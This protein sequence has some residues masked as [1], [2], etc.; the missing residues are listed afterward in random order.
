MSTYR[1]IFYHT[2]GNAKRHQRRPNDDTIDQTHMLKRSSISNS[3]GWERHATHSAVQEIESPMALSTFPDRIIPFP[4]S[5]YRMGGRRGPP[6]GHDLPWYLVRR[7][8]ELGSLR[9]VWC[10]IGWSPRNGR[11]SEVIRALRSLGTHGRGGL[12]RIGT[13]VVEGAFRL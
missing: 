4:R 6:R 1:K 3:L 7:H 2:V 11:S 13:S 8:T 10:E 5:V 12:D 9:Q